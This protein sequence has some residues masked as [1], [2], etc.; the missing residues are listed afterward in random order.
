[1]YD[2]RLRTPFSCIIAGSS[3]SGKTYL[4]SQILRVKKFLFTKPPVKTILFYEEYQDIYDKM[5]KSKAIDEVYKGM[6]SVEEIKK[7]AQPY[8]EGNGSCFIFDDSM[9]N[10]KDEISQLFTTY[11]HHLNCSMFFVTQNL[12]LQNQEY[13]TMSMNSHYI[14]LMGGN[15]SMRQ[16]KYLASQISPYKTNYVVEAFYNATKNRPYSYLLL[17]FQQQVPD[18]L[19]LRTNILPSQFPMVVYFEKSKR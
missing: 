14:I 10:I 2:V 7:M 17:D 8:K 16:M 11:S 6:P 18:H 3:S 5:L 1:M 13:R 9:H 15:R 19:R 4:L 12:F